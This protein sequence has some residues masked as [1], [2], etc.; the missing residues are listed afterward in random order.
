VIKSLRSLP[1][2]WLLL[3]ACSMLLSACTPTAA[4]PSAALKQQF[5]QMQ[6]QQQ[7]QAEQ[8]KVLQQQLEQLLQ[9]PDPIAF[10]NTAQ[11]QKP[12]ETGMVTGQPITIPAAI[13]QEVSALADSASSYLA[14]FSNQAAG[15]Y[16]VAETGFSNFL[17]EYPEHQY[18]P[19]ARYWL[20][21][22]QM[23]QG[24]LQL[25]SSNL[26]QVIIEIDNQQKA[27]AALVLL[28]KIY[29]QQQLNNEADEVLDQLRRRYPE[30]SEAQQF[31]Q[32]TEPQQPL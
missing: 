18:T 1:V 9:S 20:A 22:A 2:D 30:S 28:A 21:N 24:K 27:P 7:Q 6:Q 14:A 16:A 4:G 23:S 31:P 3:V 32:D 26:R 12:V 13:S 17:Q 8:L 10:S 25:A 5:A 29:Q 19:N 11:Q 15:R